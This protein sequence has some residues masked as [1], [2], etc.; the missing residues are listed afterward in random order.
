MKDF[1]RFIGVDYSGAEAPVAGLTGLR[2]YLAEREKAPVEVTAPQSVGR[3]WTR[4][5]IAAWL[6]DELAKPR[7]TLVGIDHGFSFPLAYFREHGL[8]S[9]WPG[10]LDDF[11]RHWPT[12]EDHMYVDFIREGVYGR[13]DLRWGS[14][15]WRR[16]CEVRSGR[17]KSVFHFDVPGSVAKSTHTGLPWLR[18]IRNTLRDAVHFWPL[19]GWE[20]PPGRSVIAEVYPSL[21]RASFPVEGL[22]RDQHDAYAVAAWLSEAD[23]DGRLAAAFRPALT[24]ADRRWPRS[25][26]GFLVYRAD[27]TD[28]LLSAAPEAVQVSH[29]PGAQKREE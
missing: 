1:A 5:A 25:R 17:A 11:Q 23:R 15:R 14:S 16:L 7:P 26:A 9:D 12:D 18:F 20:I 19:D 3:W 8:A 21:W 6:V 28:G 24:P 29:E 27:R 10:F 2:V 22:T 4:K 13:G